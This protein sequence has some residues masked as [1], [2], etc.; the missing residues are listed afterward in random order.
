M[1][2][3]VQG[4]VPPA[5]VYSDMPHPT[6]QPLARVKL[7]GPL[8]SICGHNAH[9]QRPRVLVAARVSGTE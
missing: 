8:L 6:E 5:C 9:A 7:E 3:I 1:Y 2:D 4:Q